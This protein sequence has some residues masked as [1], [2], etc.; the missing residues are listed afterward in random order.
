MTQEPPRTP[1]VTDLPEK[2]A[3]APPPNRKGGTG[4]E[5]PERDPEQGGGYP[6]GS[7]PPLRS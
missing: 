5:Y 4:G 2:P 3:P 6:E 1:P 7:T